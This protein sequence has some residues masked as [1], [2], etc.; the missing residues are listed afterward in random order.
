MLLRATGSRNA[1]RKEGETVRR[2]LCSW[3]D[4]VKKEMENV[5][6]LF[7]LRIGESLFTN[8]VSLAQAVQFLV[9]LK[10]LVLNIEKAQ[11]DYLSEGI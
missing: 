5:G 6:V 7:E 3:L 10:K 11:H 2:R 4:N 8:F 1:V 9:E